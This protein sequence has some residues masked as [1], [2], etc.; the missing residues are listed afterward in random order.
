MAFCIYYKFVF[1]GII[2]I[3]VEHF[4]YVVFPHTPC[5]NFLFRI[6]PHL[7]TRHGNW[8]R[9][10][11][12]SG[13]VSWRS[14]RSERM[15]VSSVV[16]EDSWCLVRSTAVLRS[17]MPTVWICPRDLQVSDS[18]SNSTSLLY[19]TCLTCFIVLCYYTLL[20]SLIMMLFIHGRLPFFFLVLIC[21]G[22]KI[23]WKIDEILYVILPFKCLGSVSSW[24]KS[25]I[26]T[27][28][29]FVE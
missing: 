25:L 20:W 9:R 12:W 3:K 24:K 18:F 6:S 29:G 28:A 22:E 2:R 10:L 5:D 1:K 15:N 27:Q 8:R 17:I 16:M 19:L 7:T 26:L 4:L 11:L 21:F 14:P 13:R 23:W